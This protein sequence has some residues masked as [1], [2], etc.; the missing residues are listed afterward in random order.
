MSMVPNE[1]LRSKLAYMHQREKDG[2]LQAR[3]HL[4]RM[5]LV[6]DP[7]NKE[8]TGKIF[9]SGGAGLFASPREYCS[10]SLP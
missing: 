5:P 1:E 6:V 9:K 4:H 2:S 3:D 10:K 7:H 8:E